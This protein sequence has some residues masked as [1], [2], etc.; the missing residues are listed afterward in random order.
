MLNR[1]NNEEYPFASYFLA[2][3]SADLRE[4][5]NLRIIGAVQFRQFLGLLTRSSRVS[6]LHCA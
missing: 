4:V 3:T 5:K 1:T 2:Y 6:I